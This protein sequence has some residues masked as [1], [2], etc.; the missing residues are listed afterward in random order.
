M[1]NFICKGISFMPAVA[2]ILMVIA[3]LFDIADHIKSWRKSKLKTA[4]TP[5]DN[6]EDG[7]EQK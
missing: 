2:Y 6:P 3:L 1:K 5:E 4:D 7:D